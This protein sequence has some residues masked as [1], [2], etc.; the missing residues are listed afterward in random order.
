MT[1]T[2]DHVVGDEEAGDRFDRVV[3]RVAHT[4]RAEAKRL[5]AAGGAMLDGV[6]ASPAERVAA[7][8]RI[9]VTRDKPA[10]NLAAVEVPFRIV[11]EDDAFIVVNKPAGVVVHPGAGHDAD[12]LLNGLVGVYPELRDLGPR[13][14]WG[15]VHR[16]D[17][18]TSGLLLVARSVAA[19]ERLQ[20]DLRNRTIMRRYLALAAGREF[21]NATGTVE[22]PIGRDPRRPTRMAVVQGGRPARTHYVRLA[23]WPGYTLLEV[24]LETG[25]THQIRVHL[26]AISA[27]VV[28]DLMYGSK[29]TLFVGLDRVWL[30]AVQLVFPHPAD[31]RE[32]DVRASLPTELRGVLES[33]GAPQNGA[34]PDDAMSGRGA[35]PQPRAGHGRV[36]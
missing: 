36:L 17:R 27:P 8:A 18:D 11:H 20:S 22:A 5:V 30:H 28:G 31:G 24:T 16:L 29:G 13:R 3:A 14:N 34:I 4:S 1:D 15:L 19:H 12:T 10:S 2:I 35:T 32:I 21:D 6:P 33:L 7:G 23:V 9:L 25:R 26:A